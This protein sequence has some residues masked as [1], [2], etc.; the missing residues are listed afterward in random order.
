[1]RGIL[2]HIIDEASC[3]R[4]ARA[5]TCS[6]FVLRLFLFR[7]L[8]QRCENHTVPPN[9]AN[10]ATKGC[11]SPFMVTYGIWATHMANISSLLATNIGKPKIQ[12]KALNMRWRCNEIHLF[13]WQK[14]TV[15]N[16]E[17]KYDDKTIGFSGPTSI[18]ARKIWMSPR[19]SNESSDSKKLVKL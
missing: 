15:T 16:T 11:H 7:V 2:F 18:S 13:L 4:V 6:S 12:P 19:K 10:L 8:C 5:R 1:M 9:H 3:A 17:Y 14:F